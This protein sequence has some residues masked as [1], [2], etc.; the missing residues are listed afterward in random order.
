V[1][2]FDAQGWLLLPYAV[3]LSSLVLLAMALVSQQARGATWRGLQQSFTLLDRSI[4]THLNVLSVLW[5]AGLAGAVCWC[6]CWCCCCF[7]WAMALLVSQQARGLRGHT[8]QGMQQQLT[9][10]SGSSC[11]VLATARLVEV[12][13]QRQLQGKS[14]QCCVCCH[15]WCWWAMVLLVS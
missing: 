7:C 2:C 11:T 13:T 5:C 8:G 1:L 12:W 6:A 4:Y 15:C 10:C 14:F 9:F 3:L